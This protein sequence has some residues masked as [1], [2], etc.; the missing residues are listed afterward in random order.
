MQ[1]ALGVHV[2]KRCQHADPEETG[3]RHAH[4]P[5][6]L[7]VIL[8]GGSADELEH[9]MRPR[10]RVG[11]TKQPHEVRVREPTPDVRLAPQR[12][13][14][15]LFGDLVR[16]QHLG[17]DAREEPAIPRLEDLVALAAAETADHGEIAVDL[18]VRAELPALPVAV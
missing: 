11:P 14:R 2:P 1:D 16:A 5:D 4:R 6:A 10:R 18:I 17:R 12:Q 15:S 7:E 9:E 13:K 8:D 3:L